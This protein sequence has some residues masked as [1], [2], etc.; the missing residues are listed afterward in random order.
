MFLFKEC[1]L[2]FLPV[3]FDQNLKTPLVYT[4]GVFYWFEIKNRGY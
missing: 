3:Y 4:S 1:A 2:R